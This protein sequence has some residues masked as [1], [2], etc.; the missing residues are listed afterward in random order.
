M[1]RSPNVADDGKGAFTPA[2]RE[3]IMLENMSFPGTPAT[4]AERRAAWRPLLQRV[5][6]AIRRPHTAFGPSVE[7]SP[8]FTAVYTSCETSPMQGVF[9]HRAS[10]SASLSVI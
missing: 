9:G 3:Q 8:S 6:V 7:T 1:T 4:D 2:E 10:P 5:R